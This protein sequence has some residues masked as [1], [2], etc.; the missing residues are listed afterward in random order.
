MAHLKPNEILSTT[1]DKSTE[2]ANEKISKLFVLAVFA[3]ILLS[4]AAAGANVGGFYFLSNPMLSGIGRCICSLIF[5]TGLIM[6]MLCGGEL[7]TGNNL[8]ITG[9]LAKKITIQ[10]MLRNWIIVYYGNFVGSVLFAWMF[11]NSGLL[12]TGDGLLE[13]VII[14]TAVN[15]V[16]LSI[17][18]AIIRGIF[19][20]ML[21]CLA[22]WMST[23]ATT[24]TGKI[25]AIFFPI[26]LFVA[27]GF[28]HSIANMFYI[29]VGLFADGGMTAGLTWS[30]FLLNNLLPVTLGN[31]I[32]GSFM[33]GCTY[34]F[35]YKE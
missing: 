15:K 20:N 13:T 34:Y 33:V 23:G 21:V 18:E 1:I 28:E 22:V 10:S 3:G 24:T 9:V 26:S 17:S 19:C 30:A 2:K 4:I 25:L 27:V 29:P 12:G 35:T 7:F 32:G 5:P 11:A 6:I 16:N 8:M 31:I 14:N